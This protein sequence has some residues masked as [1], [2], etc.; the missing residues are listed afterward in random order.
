VSISDG[1]SSNGGLGGTA[2]ESEDH[3]CPP[4]D[5]VGVDGPPETEEFQFLRL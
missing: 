1:G 2:G 3:Y 5:E 4:V